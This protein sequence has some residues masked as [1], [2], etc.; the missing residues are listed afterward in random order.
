MLNKRKK[1]YTSYDSLSLVDQVQKS[2][3]MQWSQ[4]TLDMIVSCHTFVSF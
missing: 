1:D 4:R 3:S 2:S